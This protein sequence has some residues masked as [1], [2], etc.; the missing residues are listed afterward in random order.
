M[1]IKQTSVNQG[2]GMSKDY[3][4][5]QVKLT[6]PS[7]DAPRPRIQS[8]EERLDN[9]DLDELLKKESFQN[10]TSPPEHEVMQPV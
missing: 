10:T 1:I 6:S 2:S 8:G 4:D 7:V 3:Y 5:Y 9:C